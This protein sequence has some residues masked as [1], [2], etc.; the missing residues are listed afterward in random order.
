MSTLWTLKCHR[1]FARCNS[2]H[3]A[4]G[5]Q[6]ASISSSTNQPLSLS[7]PFKHV[8]NLFLG[9][10][11]ENNVN[12]GKKTSVKQL[13]WLT[14]M[15]ELDSSCGS[16]WI[17]GEIFPVSYFAC[18]VTSTFRKIYIEYIELL[19]RL[20][21][22]IRM[23][24]LFTSHDEL[25]WNLSTPETE[26]GESWGQNY[27]ELYMWYLLKQIEISI[28]NREQVL[29]HYKPED[30]SSE[31]AQHKSCLPSVLATQIQY[32]R[33]TQWKEK[34]NTTKLSSDFDI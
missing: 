31:I 25:S 19:S 1:Q 28:Q 8:L 24:K 9:K 29:I 33:P 15:V 12:I 17:S 6:S 23:L 4:N 16:I 3:R 22:Y 11:H 21:S 30:M 14:K 20:M 7:L 13:E 34:T 5:R 18:Q 2:T 32:L 26:A 27:T 10:C